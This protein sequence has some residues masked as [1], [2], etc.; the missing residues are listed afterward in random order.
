[1]TTDQ[2]FQGGDYREEP[3][4][5]NPRHFRWF[6]RRGSFLRSGGVRSYGNPENPPGTTRFAQV[7]D[8]Y[9]TNF[10]P[11]ADANNLILQM[12]TWE[13]HDVGGHLPGF[14]LET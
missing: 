11:G 14:A 2:A 10:I 8:H 12:H 6:G 1:M 7:V 5:G 9:K 4:K 13:Q 3:V